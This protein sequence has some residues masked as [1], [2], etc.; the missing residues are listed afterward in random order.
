MI[1][2]RYQFDNL[3]HLMTIDAD[4]RAVTRDD[5]AT[6]LNTSEESAH[7]RM[8]RLALDDFVEIIRPEHRCDQYQYRISARGVQAYRAHLLRMDG[9][10]GPPPLHASIELATIT[11]M[12]LHAYGID[13]TNTNTKQLV[14]DDA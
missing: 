10:T 9:V 11:M 7:K 4:K 12:A 5:L 6:T 2:T 14:S 1:L 3:D 13:A 8:Y